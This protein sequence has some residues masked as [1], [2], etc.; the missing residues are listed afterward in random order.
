MRLH[1][2]LGHNDQAY[3]ILVR[4]SLDI[5]SRVDYG[6]GVRD[7]TGDILKQLNVGKNVLLLC[8]TSLPK[9]WLAIV[10]QSLDMQGFKV[11][12]H[13]LPDGE[14]AKNLDVLAECWQLMQAEEFTRN[15]SVVAVGGG[16]VTDIAGFCASTYLRGINLFLIP[17]TL[18]A[19][20]D[21]SVGGKTGINLKAGKNLAGSFYFPRSVIVDPEFLTTL[22]ARDLKSGMGEIVKYAFIEDTIAEATD[23][24]KGPRALHSSLADNFAGGIDASNPALGPLISCCIRM[25]LAVVIKDPYEKNLRRCLNLGHTLGHAIEKVSKY[26]VSHGESVSIGTVFAFKLANKIGIV[27][28]KDTAQVE[29]LNNIL[30]LP[31]EVPGDLD[32]DELVRV[33]AFDKKRQGDSIKFVLPEKKLGRVSLDFSIT[34]KELSKYLKQ[35]QA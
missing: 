16:A 25:K 18:L 15:D 29:T 35:E 26:A 9:Q 22:P 33:L 12:L 11:R 13:L 31:S 7:K 17:T 34:A 3:T 10:H 19:Q 21:A 27:S 32:R 23:Y 20:V 1:S 4:S 24:K 14:D 8:Q 5:Q 30:G 28:D 2:Q 6:Y